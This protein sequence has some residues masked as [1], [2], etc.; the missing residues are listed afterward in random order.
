MKMKNEQRERKKCQ[1]SNNSTETMIAK[2]Q[3]K[4]DL[5]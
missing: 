2:E 3:I 4:I 5:H 1:I